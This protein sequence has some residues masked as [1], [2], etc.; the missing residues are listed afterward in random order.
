MPWTRAAFAL[1]L[2]LPFLGVELAA[3]LHPASRPTSGEESLLRLLGR[4]PVL[5]CDGGVCQ[6]EPRLRPIGGPGASFPRTPPPGSLRVVCIGGS[7]TLGWPYQPRGGYPE[8]LGAIL[9]DALPGRRVEVINLGFQMWDGPRLEHVF[10]EALTLRPTVIAVRDGYNS[11]ASM[12]LRRPAGGPLRRG[13][14]R[15]WLRLF[16]SS[17]AFRLAR[18]AFGPAERVGMEPFGSEPLSAE[19][20]AWL[21]D[22]H[23]LR[24][25]RFAARAKSAGAALFVLGL[26]YSS[27]KGPKPHLDRLHEA[28]ESESR[29]LGLP[30]IPL[31][32]LGDDS[33]VD[34]SHCDAE[35]Y[36][37]IAL[38]VARAL[39]DSGFPSPD[40]RW[41]WRR[42][43]PPASHRAR[44]GLDDPAF[45]AIVRLRLASSKLI[46]GDASGAARDVRRALRAA[47]SA[48]LVPELI[49]SE[50]RSS[51]EALY[52][53]AFLRLRAEG[54]AKEPSRPENR[55]LLG[56][57]PLRPE[58]AP[59]RA[60]RAK[61]IIER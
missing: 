44:L 37:L 47:P 26:P 36:R 48:D 4:D 1:L 13:A 19:K 54:V 59:S 11:F 42:V 9:A 60:R 32:E 53:E 30:F 57:P 3:R 45:G 16:A 10:E 50:R 31:S 61:A 39:S 12:P 35:G 43:A 46:L 55:A 51:F 52:R 38:A 29:A 21:V 49:R 6:I 56:L 14:Q 27:A 24:L 8:W 22:D 40:A 17:A 34:A 25:R 20:A 58:P 33:F 18:R 15:A 5:S 7:T 28:S 23:R 2:P 41:R